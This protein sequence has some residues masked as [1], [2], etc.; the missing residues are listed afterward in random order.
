MERKGSYNKGSAGHVRNASTYRIMQ[1]KFKRW[2]G[3]TITAFVLVI[4]FG[5]SPLIGSDLQTSVLSSGETAQLVNEN[6]TE[7]RKNIVAYQA[8]LIAACKKFDLVD[9]VDEG[10]QLMNALSNEALDVHIA[11]S[12]VVDFE[13]KTLDARAKAACKYEGPNYLNELKAAQSKLVDFSQKY[14]SFEAAS[15]LGG[16]VQDLET[17]VSKLEATLKACS[18]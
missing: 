16:Q 2:R 4:A 15:A 3:P 13:Q 7:A 10:T 18:Q 8:D 12:S 5:L 9:C 6:P 14:D 17:A 1:E 11:L